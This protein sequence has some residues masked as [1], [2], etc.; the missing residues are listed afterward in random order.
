MD[1]AYLWTGSGPRGVVGDGPLNIRA[2]AST[3]YAVRGLAARYANVPI[4]CQVTGQT[5]AGPYR[6][7]NRWNRLASGQ[8]V[9]H[10][11]VSAIH[12]GAVPLC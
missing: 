8:Y 3:G 2:G 6:T 11:Y 7:T 12:G 9:S 10:A 5:V 1:V 4:Q